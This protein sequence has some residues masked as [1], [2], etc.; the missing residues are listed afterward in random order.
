MRSRRK[1]GEPAEIG[2]FL[3]VIVFTDV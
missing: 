3:N 2:T 1:G